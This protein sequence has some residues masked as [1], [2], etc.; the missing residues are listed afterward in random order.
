MDCKAII[1]L[2]GFIS[3]QVS[4]PY[5]SQSKPAFF[6]QKNCEKSAFGVWNFVLELYHRHR[7]L[8]EDYS[9]DILKLG[10]LFYLT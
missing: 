6:G 7:D 1:N 5:I 9:T 4:M 2:V 8:L 10:R 3:P